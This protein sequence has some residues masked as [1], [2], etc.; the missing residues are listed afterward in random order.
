VSIGAFV[1]KQHPPTI[2]AM[3]VSVRSKRPLWEG[4]TQFIEEN[5]RVK[6]DFAFYGKNLGGHSD[7]GVGVGRSPLSIQERAASRCRL[8]SVK[9]S[10]KRPCSCASVLRCETFL[11]TL[12]RS[13]K[14]GGSSSPSS[15]SRIAVTSNTCSE[16]ER[17]R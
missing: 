8:L 5:Y 14:G 17:T 13:P 3:I 16:S 4:L 12:A 1:D 2:E 7:F 11:E 10:L 9:R 15:Q 6:R